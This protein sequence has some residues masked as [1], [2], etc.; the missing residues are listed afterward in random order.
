MEKKAGVLYLNFNVEFTPDALTKVR[1]E[2]NHWIN[3]LAKNP[4]FLPQHTPPPTPPPVQAATTTS[5]DTIRTIW[6]ALSP[7]VQKLVSSAVRSVA[8]ERQFTMEQWAGF[9][10]MTKNEVPTVKAWRRALAKWEARFGVDLVIGLWDRR[11]FHMN[12]RMSKEV[13]DALLRLLPND[14]EEPE[15]VKAD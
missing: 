1:D 14:E 3:V 9:M 13:H 8:P 2:L 4:E 11:N 15:K 12:Y 6:N 10:N 7:N 5:E